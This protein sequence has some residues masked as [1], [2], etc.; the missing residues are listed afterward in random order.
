MI[1]SQ[2]P[3]RRAFTMSDIVWWIIIMI[4]L[5]AILLPSLAR[6][7]EQA[8]RAV[9]QANLRGIGMSIVI[10][11]NDNQE[12]F[13][14]HYQ[15]WQEKQTG[16]PPEH[17]VRW[18]GMMGSTDAL[19]ISQQTSPAV[20][21]EAG[22]PSRS[23]FLLI[24]NGMST[25]LQ[26]ICPSSGDEADD[27]RNYGPDAGKARSVLAAQP[28]INRFDFRGWRHLSYG[29]QLP[30]G[31]KGRPWQNLDVRVA[32]A[33]EK[34]PYTVDGGPGLE[35]T[36]TCVD[37]RSAVEP[38]EAWSSTTPEE[39]LRRPARDW[40]PYN[41]RNHAGEGQSVLFA[42]GHVNFEKRPFVGVHND[43]IYT[44]QTGDS[45]IGAIIGIMPERDRLVGP[46]THTDSFI[47]P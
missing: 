26:F 16:S 34:G 36:R 35:G 37:G 38:P 43:N 44:I 9:C 18:Q 17:G 28:G 22:H 19:R 2:P 14:I 12:W 10:Y 46:M 7:R 27:L 33:A 15:R 1:I 20:S 42:D 32:V 23:L 29:Y 45:R 47:V 25:P 5:V 3:L 13:P 30:Y 40:Q 6:A 21:P 11:S 4:L 39:V 41:S 8:K 24:T 31:Q